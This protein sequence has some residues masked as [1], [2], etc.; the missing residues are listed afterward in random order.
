MMDRPAYSEQFADDRLPHVRPIGAPCPVTRDWAFGTGSG[1]GVKVAVID[2]GVDADHP[3]V[4]H[5]DGYVAL[6]YAPD[7][8]DGV[9]AV[10]G[11]HDDLYGHGTACAAIIRMLAPE[12]E[13]YSVRVLGER[14]TGKVA[15]FAA[16]LEWAL[17]NGVHVANLSLSAHREQDVARLHAL[18][19]R[20][21][22]QDLMMVSAVN[23]Q[24]VPS[25][26][27]QFSSVFS[28][29]AHEGR[30]PESWDYNPAGPVEWGAPGLD[31]EV[32]WS[33]GGRIV[34]SGNSF[35][36]PHIAG[37]VARVVAAHPH[38]SVFQVKT[39]LQALARNA[40]STGGVDA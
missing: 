12:V 27:S 8:P 20:A 1:A 13:L 14:L 30:D 3:D 23:N 24:R 37:Q 39:V 6:E 10:E 38:L 11:R 18:A 4:G 29:A 16:G 17:A 21:Y 7:E 2:S 25:Y 5:V 34:A 35:A 22:F 32:A 9:V 40:C 28:V 15:V 26:P 31:V 33:A 36:A 19:E